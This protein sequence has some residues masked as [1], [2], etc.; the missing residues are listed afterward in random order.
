MANL[1]AAFSVGLWHPDQELDEADATSRASQGIRALLGQGD[2]LKT[3]IGTLADLA[4]S[5][6]ALVRAAI[7]LNQ[8][9]GGDPER[10]A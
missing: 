7:A 8:A 9:S 6:V 2:P 1:P 5:L 10:V 3:Y 4:A